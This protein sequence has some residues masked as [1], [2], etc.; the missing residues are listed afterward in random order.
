MTTYYEDWEKIVD[1]V[2]EE[3]YYLR[4][5]SGVSGDNPDIEK[6]NAAGW[7]IT[8]TEDTDHIFKGDTLQGIVLN[9]DELRAAIAAADER[10]KY[11]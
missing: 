6:L 5:V 3:I 4:K 11:D 9:A 10:G 1:M 7:E 8:V 2:A